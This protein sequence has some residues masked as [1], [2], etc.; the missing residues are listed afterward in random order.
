M[1]DK[2]QKL[3]WEAYQQLNE[4][5]SADETMGAIINAWVKANNDTE[6]FKRY[7]DAIRS[8]TK[9]DTLNQA[10]GRITNMPDAE[11]DLGMLDVLSS[12]S[13]EKPSRPSL[14]GLPDDHE[15]FQSKYGHLDAKGDSDLLDLNPH[16]IVGD[17]V[18]RLG[19]RAPRA[20]RDMMSHVVR[21]L[22]HNNF[23]TNLENAPEVWYIEANGREARIEFQIDG[24]ERFLLCILEHNFESSGDTMTSTYHIDNQNHVKSLVNNIRDISGSISEE[25]DKQ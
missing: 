3:L 7:V 18:E 20:E 19:A 25:P 16:N 24:H 21:A 11:V 5:L 17:I 2:D 12:V 9:E 14:P 10:I 22:M 6:T 1:H 13:G 23:K 8:A 15:S 4:A